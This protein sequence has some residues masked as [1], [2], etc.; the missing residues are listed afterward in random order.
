VREVVSRNLNRFQADGLIRVHHREI[1]VADPEGL[2][3]EADA[4]L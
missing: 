4:E 3:R 2:Q 1:T